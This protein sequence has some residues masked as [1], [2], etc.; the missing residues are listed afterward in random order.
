MQCLLTPFLS[1]LLVESCVGGFLVPVLC[2]VLCFAVLVDVVATKR[3]AGP[4]TTAKKLP[5]LDA[6]VR[7]CRMEQL[8]S[9]ETVSFL[10][11]DEVARMK[12]PSLYSG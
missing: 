8:A 2:A 11:I 1:C 9:K 7:V 3:A 12:K 4:Q 10:D 6:S 5:V